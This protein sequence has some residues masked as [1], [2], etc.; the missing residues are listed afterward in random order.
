[1]QRCSAIICAAGS[2]DIFFRRDQ[3]SPWQPIFFSV[4]FLFA[5]FCESIHSKTESNQSTKFEKWNRRNWRM[6]RAWLLQVFSLKVRYFVTKS[7]KIEIGEKKKKKKRSLFV[8]ISQVFST[9]YFSLTEHS[10]SVRSHFPATH[11]CLSIVNLCVWRSKSHFFK[12]KVFAHFMNFYHFFSKVFI[13]FIKTQQLAPSCINQQCRV[14]E[15]S[16]DV[17]WGQ[18]HTCFS[19]SFINFSQLF[20]TFLNSLHFLH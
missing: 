5:A 13:F 2:C 11:Y 10:P 3:L 17:F 6:K 7:A 14:M 12:T 1:M 16:T 19:K 15:W 4:L 20:S 8:N 18:N 9:F